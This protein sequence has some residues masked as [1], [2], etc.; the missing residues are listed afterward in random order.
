MVVSVAAAACSRGEGEEVGA[1]SEAREAPPAPAA[2]APRA[3][4]DRPLEADPP[5][6]VVRGAG[7]T[8]ELE[9]PGTVHLTAT[10]RWGRPVDARYEDLGYLRRALPALE[11]GLGEEQAAVLRGALEQLAPP[12]EAAAADETP[13][14]DP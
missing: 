5:E 13:P 8:V 10:D 3:E 11:R 2:P 4:A 7:V 14:R 1:R 12:D 6:N 9:E